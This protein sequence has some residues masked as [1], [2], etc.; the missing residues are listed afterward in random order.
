MKIHHC[1]V[2]SLLL[3]LFDSISSLPATVFFDNNEWP[4]DLISAG[5]S[6]DDDEVDPATRQP[7][8]APTVNLTPLPTLQPTSAPTVQPKSGP[9]TLSCA[10]NEK[11]FHIYFMTDASSK[12]QNRIVIR[13]QKKS[14]WFKII[15]KLKDFPKSELYHYSMCLAMDSCNKFILKDKKE[16][17]FRKGSY[18]E[19]YWGGYMVEHDTFLPGMKKQVVEFGHCGQDS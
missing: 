10:V 7:T 9:P 5:N 19:L 15:A 1:V 18:Y 12:W 6:T 4:S 13:T 17:G 14:G 8:S 11:P 3:L 16:N 2:V